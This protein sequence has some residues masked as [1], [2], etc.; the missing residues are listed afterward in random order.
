MGWGEQK[1]GKGG[2][3]VASVKEGEEG[4]RER[5]HIICCYSYTS[6]QTMN[7]SLWLRRPM[8]IPRRRVEILRKFNL[9]F[10]TGASGVYASVCQHYN[11]LYC[12]LR[13]WIKGAHSAV[14]SIQDASVLYC[15]V[16]ANTVLWL[17]YISCTSAL[18]QFLIKCFLRNSRQ[19]AKV[20]T[21]HQQKQ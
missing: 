8:R 6:K 14:F 4:G 12:T 20:N 2:R 7:S 1:G 16:V 10:F 19:S 9:E 3:R 11:C 5:I 15:T 13:V 17:M 21:T 18:L